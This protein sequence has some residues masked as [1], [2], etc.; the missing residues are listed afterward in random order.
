IMTKIQNDAKSTESTV[1]EHLAS[2]ID[3]AKIKFDKM[4]A[5]VI[6]PSSYVKRGNEYTADIFIAATSEE[7][8]I[9]VY[10]GSFT[11]AVQK[12]AAGDYNVIKGTEMPLSGARKLDVVGGMGKIKEIASGSPKY[13]GVIKLPDPIKP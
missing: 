9:E 1:L 8:N 7:A 13:Q 2:Q 6:A 10:L 11:S 4:A 3:A 5:R 12:D